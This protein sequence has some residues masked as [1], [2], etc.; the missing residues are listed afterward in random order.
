M[1]RLLALLPVLVGV[2][3]VVAGVCVEL[4][5]GWSMVVAGAFIV[6]GFFDWGRG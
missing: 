2:G 4:G 1:T 6:V 3:L 5:A